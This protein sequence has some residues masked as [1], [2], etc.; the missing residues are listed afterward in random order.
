MCVNCV[1]QGI[2]YVGGAVGGLQVMAHRARHKRLAQEQEPGATGA[3]D[4]LVD[5]PGGTE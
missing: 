4:E 1:A 2:V 5:A 3:D